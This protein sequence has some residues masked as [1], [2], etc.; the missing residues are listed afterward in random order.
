[1]TLALRSWTLTFKLV[2]HLEEHGSCV[3]DT[4]ATIKSWT[5][6]DMFVWSI[7]K[8]RR[9]ETRKK[10]TW[11]MISFYILHLLKCMRKF[12]VYALCPVRGC[13]VGWFSRWQMVRVTFLTI[14]TLLDSMC[15][16]QN[17]K[18]L[19]SY[20]YRYEKSSGL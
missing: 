16:C 2:Y 17:F 6:H 15:R 13:Q 19:T 18:N 4:R 20:R 12:L 5:R 3:I 10:I 8:A 11:V 14:Y 1:M 9:R 7:F